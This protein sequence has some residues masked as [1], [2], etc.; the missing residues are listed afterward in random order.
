MKHT[1]E[2]R[3]AV[4]SFL[5]DPLDPLAMSWVRDLAGNDALLSLV[6]LPAEIKESLK[7]AV[8]ERDDL[9]DALR[10][11]ILH[12]GTTVVCQDVPEFNAARAAILKAT[13]G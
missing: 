7:S 6:A 10:G 3:D 12:I 1:L 8:C 13:E 11:L 5:I 9:L 4:W 2:L